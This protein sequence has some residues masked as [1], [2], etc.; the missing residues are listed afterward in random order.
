[1]FQ[2]I[3]KGLQWAAPALAGYFLNDIGDG[4]SKVLPENVRSKVK[5]DQGNWKPWFVISVLAVAGAVLMM[6]FKKIGGGKKGRGMF[7][8]ALGAAYG[9]DLL[10]GGAIFGGDGYVMATALVTLTTGSGV[11]T[12]VNLS[13]L[14]ERLA[15]AAATQLTGV[16]VTVQGDGVVFDSDANG[17]S[18]IGVNRVIGQVTNNFILTLS[19]SLIKGK[20][21]L[22][23]FTNSAAQTPTVYYD[24]DSTSSGNAGDEP[25]F[26]QMMKVPLLVGGNDFSD[27]ATLSLPSLAATDTLTITYR[28]GTTQSGITRADLQYKLGYTQNVVNSPIYQIDN[29][30]QTIKSVTVI[31]G[32]SQTGYLQRWAPSVSRAS[33]AGQA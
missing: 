30:A 10:T 22:F 26:L 21:V 31:A 28:D 2:F 17:L 29:F 13:F 14:P 8:A 23:E 16:K 9:A 20:N 24:S 5:D 19:N 33:I 11:V 7:A 4:V 18:H 3:V 27:F 6:V 1:M 15:Y 12:S 25:L 32:S